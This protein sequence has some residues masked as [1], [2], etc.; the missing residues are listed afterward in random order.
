MKKAITKMEVGF[1]AINRYNLFK[2]VPDLSGARKKLLAVITDKNGKKP[3][4]HK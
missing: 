1:K 3:L 2:S 4:I